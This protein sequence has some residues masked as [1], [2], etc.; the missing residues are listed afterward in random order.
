M[1]LLV[2][3]KSLESSMGSRIATNKLLYPISIQV[4]SME[5]GD[6]MVHALGMALSIPSVLYRSL[7]MAWG[8]STYLTP[9]FCATAQIISFVQLH[10]KLLSSIPLSSQKEIR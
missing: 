6:S 7:S 8:A 9:R 4:S 5:V 1:E 10:K 3:T 2:D